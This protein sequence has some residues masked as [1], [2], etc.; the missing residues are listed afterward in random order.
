MV[1]V[2]A[3]VEDGMEEGA[4][5][6]RCWKGKGAEEGKSEMGR[7][8]K[9]GRKWEMGRMGHPP[10]GGGWPSGSRKRAPPPTPIP[11]PAS[12]TTFPC[13]MSFA[14]LAGHLGGGV[15]P[16]L[17]QPQS[18]QQWREPPPTLPSSESSSEPPEPTSSA[19]SDS[20]LGSSITTTTL[21][22]DGLEMGDGY[23]GSSPDVGEEMGD[24]EEMEDVED[25]TMR[26]SREQHP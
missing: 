5:H 6:W 21:S 26:H 2:G 12:P 7:K 17:P 9:M 25:W 3:M 10:F 23:E 15:A 20:R 13:P 16:R 1:A 18:F 24:G 14:D 8:W 19:T 4:G 22:L 11:L